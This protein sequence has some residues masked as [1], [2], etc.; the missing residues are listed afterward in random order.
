MA[1]FSDL[2]SSLDPNAIVFNRR[3]AHAHGLS[4]HQLRTRIA[5]GTIVQVGPHAF[6]GALVDMTPLARLSC[7]VADIGEPVWICRQTAAWLH[8]F[9]GYPPGRPFHLVVTRDRHLRR[10]GAVIHQ[11]RRPLDPIDRTEIHG[12]PVTAAPRTVIDLARSEGVERLTLAIDSGI[13]DG[14]FTEESLL[15]RVHAMSG[16][17]RHGITRLLRAID[18]DS[19]IRGGHS[20]LERAFLDL[21]HQHRLPRPQTQV[22]M[23]RSRRRVMR[24]DFVFPG[25]DI[26]VEVLGIR[27]HRTA[28]QIRRDTE[29]LNQLILDGWRPFQYTSHHVFSEPEAVIEE[30]S[31]ALSGRTAPRTPTTGSPAQMMP[32]RR[33]PRAEYLTMQTTARTPSRH[34]IFLPSS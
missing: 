8:G 32:R 24:V 33:R 25:T 26:V 16:R 31:K 28:D 20:F 12:L 13:R 11:I 14:R 29:R 19:P 30:L 10:P 4:D 27:Y 22:V 7:L 18:G 9:D 2:R 1:R 15:R 21:L 6:R 5:D 17:G 3:Q 23:S 34:P